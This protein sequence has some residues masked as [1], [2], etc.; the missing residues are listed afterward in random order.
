MPKND[1]LFQSTDKRSPYKDEEGEQNATSGGMDDAHTSGQV[2]V[3]LGDSAL[4]EVVLLLIQNRKAGKDIYT[5][6]RPNWRG[7]DSILNT[8]LFLK[9]TG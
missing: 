2:R 4:E 9:S 8:L 6:L 7:A 3:W 5:D 1:F